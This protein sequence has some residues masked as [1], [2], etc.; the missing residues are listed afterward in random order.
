MKIFLDT[1]SLIKLYHREED[2]NELELVFSKEKITDIFL[3]EISKI[4]FTSAIWKKVRTK[5]IA[6][7]AAETT[8]GLFEK[9]FG[10]YSFVAASSFIIEQARVLCSKYGL[11][12]LRTLDSTQ[13]STSISLSKEVSVFFSADILL[14]SLLEAERLPVRL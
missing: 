14:K 8:L 7:S 1:S 12:G 9:D 6:R 10:K 2:T 5:E 11:E 3:A 13:L 4:E